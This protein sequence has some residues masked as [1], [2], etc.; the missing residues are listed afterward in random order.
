MKHRK[1]LIAGIIILVVGVAL[2]GG[3]IVYGIDRSKNS[4]QKF[5][6]NS[7][8]T[9][10]RL[11]D[12]A[13]AYMENGYPETAEDVIDLNNIIM[14][15]YYG[16]IVSSDELIRELVTMQR[17]LFSDYLLENNDFE[18]QYANVL[19]SADILYEKKVYIYNIEAGSVFYS[20]G[21]DMCS[22]PITEF[23]NNYEK[24]YWNYYL[25]L[26]DEGHWKIHNYQRTDKSFRNVIED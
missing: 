7:R 17:Q 22:V 4:D 20:S 5:Y 19:E 3:T 2:I 8:S 9:G 1:S 14:Q 13:L 11:Y 26:D 16:K 15:L 24:M 21:G 12:K 25:K 10:Q 6:Q 23:M 18:D